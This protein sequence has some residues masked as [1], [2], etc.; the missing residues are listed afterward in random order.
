MQNGSD[1]VRAQ[2]PTGIRCTDPTGCHQH[3]VSDPAVCTRTG[4]EGIG[5]SE[6]GVVIIGGE[7]RSVIPAS[8]Q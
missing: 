4:L 7:V 8:D 6:V 2:L 1:S 5:G 3:N